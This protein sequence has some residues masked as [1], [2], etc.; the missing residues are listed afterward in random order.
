M[1]KYLNIEIPQSCHENWNT[2]QPNAQGR[3][4]LSCQKTVVDFTAMTGAELINFFS[5]KRDNVCGR[6]TTEQ[7][8]RDILIPIKKYNWFKYLIHFTIP[9]LLITLKDGVK[10]AT[11]IIHK[12]E[13]TPT[14][15]II[16]GD[17][18]I[19]KRNTVR[20]KLVDVKGQPL[21][22]TTILIKESK[23]GTT[24]NEYGYFEF[25]NPPKFPFIL[26][27]NA[28][29][30]IGTE[31]IVNTYDLGELTEKNNTLS[32]KIVDDSGNGVAFA[33]ILIKDTKFGTITRNDGSFILKQQSTKDI[34]VVSALGFKAKEIHSDFFKKIQLLYLSKSQDFSVGEIIITK[35]RELKKKFSKKQN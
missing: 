11:R 23:I 1:P 31:I 15:K 27:V 7:L 21:A 10:A 14:K 18:I 29:C 33:T 6:F 5:K 9:A 32:G 22:N 4:C 3:H 2:M 35:K 13:I 16:Q 19:V 26:S 17:T 34:L 30:F 25:N 20:G 28:D 12:T 24:T 8:D